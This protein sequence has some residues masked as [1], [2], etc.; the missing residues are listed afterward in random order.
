MIINKKGGKGEKSSEICCL[1]AGPPDDLD[2]G[3][4][5]DS[6]QGNYQAPA[7]GV[8]K[9]SVWWEIEPSPSLLAGEE[10][11]GG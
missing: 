3:V 11:G 6:L 1:Y 7:A 5:L 2:R 4:R 9:V 10:L 8:C